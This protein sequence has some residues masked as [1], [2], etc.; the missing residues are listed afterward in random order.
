MT[1]S[2]CKLR[3]NCALPREAR[4]RGRNAL[5][6]ARQHLRYEAPNDVLLAENCSNVFFP[7]RFKTVSYSDDYIEFAGCRRGGSQW[8]CPDFACAPCFQVSFPNSYHSH[9][10]TFQLSYYNIYLLLDDPWPKIGAF[11]QVFDAASSL[12]PPSNFDA[13]RK[14]VLGHGIAIKM[15]AYN[16]YASFLCLL[17]TLKRH[18]GKIS[19]FRAALPSAALALF[20][21]KFHAHRIHA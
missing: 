14:D 1:L 3:G 6:G 18:R 5:P 4:A 10:I 9:K 12:P 13:Q 16:K 8:A 17:F 15:Q 2:N 21:A 11:L 19:W 20:L 7:T